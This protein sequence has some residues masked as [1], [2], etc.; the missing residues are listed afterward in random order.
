MINSSGLQNL[1]SALAFLNFDVT[2]ALLLFCNNTVP[3]IQLTVRLRRF[4]K[5]GCQISACNPARSV[6]CLDD[7]GFCVF[8]SICKVVW[9]DDR[10]HYDCGVPDGMLVFCHVVVAVLRC[11]HDVTNS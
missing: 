8:S 7:G 1:F 3:S 5:P 9:L 11:V 4:I 6:D 2:Y 10:G